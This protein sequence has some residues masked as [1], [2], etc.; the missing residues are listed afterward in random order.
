MIALKKPRVYYLRDV[1]RCC[2][3]TAFVAFLVGYVVARVSG[4]SLPAVEYQQAVASLNTLDAETAKNTRFLSL[5][6]VAV[7]KR[8]EAAGVASFVLN[9]LGDAGFISRPEPATD[10]LLRFNLR[11]FAV[12]D[13]RYKAHW[14]TWERLAEG[15]PFFHIRTRVNDG[16]KQPV[17]VTV[18][19]PWIPEA[20]SAELR[21]KAASAGAVLRLEY[22]LAKV[23]VPPHYYTLTETP[24]TEAG[25]LAQLGVKS[26][27][28][29][30]GAAVLSRV[31][32][33]HPRRVVSFIGPNGNGWLTRDVFAADADGDT[34][35]QPLSKATNP[36]SGKVET[37]Y[38][39]DATEAIA[40]QANGL[41][42]YALFDGAGK[43]QD[44]VPLGGPGRSIA[45]DYSE[46]APSFDGVIVPMQGCVRCHSK[47]GLQDIPDVISSLS[48]AAAYDEAQVIRGF[49]DP[50]QV[51]L[52][53]KQA[54]E[55]FGV[56]LH[57]ACDLNSQQLSD[58]LA[59]LVRTQAYLLVTPQRAALECG[60][61]LEQFNERAARVADPYV[62]LLGRGEAIH[63][64]SWESS[65]PALMQV[66]E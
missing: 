58:G 42:R 39:H 54:R 30:K 43:R 62:S 17:E 47:D 32:F 7:E 19:A 27:E 65:Y 33:G 63:R 51:Q 13:A 61:T 18:D 36:A 50:G 10:T 4:Q 49:Y 25:W 24:D 66:S 8:A 56:A 22:W 31:A 1:V 52:R 23:T 44:A 29:F 55:Q 12:S 64:E 16:K 59:E 53:L 41:H 5:A 6:T 37:L 40:A 35:R 57:A 11:Q 45:R 46:A 3:I 21:A 14:E 34:V 26:N 9:S 20:L 15:E 48:A 2:A 38:R 28:G 60:L